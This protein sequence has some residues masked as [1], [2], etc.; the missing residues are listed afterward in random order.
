MESRG[1]VV[2]AVGGD[3]QPLIDDFEQGLEEV[4]TQLQGLMEQWLS[5]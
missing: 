5:D 2:D 1:T 3:W 4:Q